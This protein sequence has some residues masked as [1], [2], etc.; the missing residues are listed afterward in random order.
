MASN[1]VGHLVGKTVDL[2][3]QH[4]GIVFATKGHNAVPDEVQKRLRQLSTTASRLTRPRWNGWPMTGDA[5]DVD[6]GTLD[7]GHTVGGSAQ[8]NDIT[9][10]EV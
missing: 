7:V 5:G 8:Q 9:R 1:G 3:Q 4:S 2:S 6:T 10:A